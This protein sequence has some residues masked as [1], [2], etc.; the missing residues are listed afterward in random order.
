MGSIYI[1]GQWIEGR[2]ICKEAND[3][4]S[5]VD[6]ILYLSKMPGD[7]SV[8]SG[9]RQVYQFLDDWKKTNTKSSA[10]LVTD[11]GYARMIHSY[12][13]DMNEEE[14]NSFEMKD[15]EIRRYCI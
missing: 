8:F 12:F 7:K 14:Y 15:G 2:N 1:A 4:L 5:E 6:Q 10:L 11:S 3:T 13:C 9:M